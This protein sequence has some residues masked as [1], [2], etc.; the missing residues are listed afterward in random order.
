MDSPLSYVLYSLPFNTMMPHLFHL[1]II[2]LVT[3]APLVGR[4]AS[5]WR[6]LF[7]FASL[8]LAGIEVAVVASYD[9]TVHGATAHN[10]LAIPRVLHNGLFYTRL[11]GFAL[12]DV[13]SA[14]L[15]YLSA[16]N[17]LFYTPPTPAEQTE[18]MLS[19]IVKTV[20]STSPKLYALNVAKN[21][22]MRDEDLRRSDASYWRS[23]RETEK[24]LDDLWREPE[25][26]RAVKK[27]SREQQGELAKAQSAKDDGDDD[28]ESEQV[29]TTGFVDMLTAQLEKGEEDE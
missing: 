13:V 25:V 29:D 17:R 15:I 11:I 3:S 6:K 26:A 1:F 7:V 10:R 28:D 19:A 12:F 2:G 5:R 27:A 22:V 16:T 8:C 4:Q 9:P 20:A 24:K 21:A 23:V 14:G 18:Q